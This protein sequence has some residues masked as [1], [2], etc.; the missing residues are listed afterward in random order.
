MLELKR[1][2][3]NVTELTSQQ[4]SVCGKSF[5]AD[6]SGALFWPSQ[7]AV[8]VADL[9]IAARVARK[10]GAGAGRHGLNAGETL[11]RLAAV[12]DHFN[13][14]TVIALGCGVAGVS[15]KRNGE[16][17]E[18]ARETTVDFEGTGQV[19]D[20]VQIDDEDRKTLSIMQ[21]HCKWIWVSDENYGSLGGSVCRAFEAEGLT[22]RHRPEPGLATH[23]IAGGLCPAVKISRHGHE[24]R[25]PCFIGDGLRVIL[26]AFATFAGGHNILGAAFEPMFG[27]RGRTILMLG[28]DGLYPI[29]P[30]LLAPD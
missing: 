28:H 17:D 6:M 15:G 22:V 18:A 10:P 11:A 4:I 25:R 30:R 26:P 1:N 8:I 19:G 12:V 21:D 2:R 23:E 27:A 3:L 24:I 29:A 7:R 9:K 14:L 5:Y 13:A 20:G 16:T